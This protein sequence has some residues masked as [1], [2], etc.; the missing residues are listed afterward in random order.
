MAPSPLR[1]HRSPV[2]SPFSQNRTRRPILHI[3]PQAPARFNSRTPAGCDMILMMSFL[4]FDCF[5]SR[6]PAGCDIHGSFSSPSSCLDSRHYYAPD[7]LFFKLLLHLFHLINC[8]NQATTKPI[9]LIHSATALQ[10][11]GLVVVSTHAPPQ[12]CDFT[13]GM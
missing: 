2:F 1:R 9:L 3:C 6:T 4:F 7:F 8:H 12:G 10:Q 11:T 5:N 13:M